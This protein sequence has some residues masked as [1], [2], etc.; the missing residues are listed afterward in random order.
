MSW[1][2]REACRQVSEFNREGIKL[3][4]VAI[5]I[6]AEQFSPAFVD[7][8]RA[9][10][11]ETGIDP[12]QLELGLT[13]AVMSSNA[14]ETVSA[15]RS[16]KES[17]IY[18]SVDDFGTGYSPLNYLSQYP[19]D[20]LKIDRSFLLEAGRSKTGA[21]LVVAIIAMA[22]SL[23]LRVLATG[24]ETESQFRFLTAHGASLIQGYLFSRPVSAEELKPMLSPWHFVDQ[25]QSLAAAEAD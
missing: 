8:V 16:L 4:K 5:N 3:G 20:E 25:V 15:L 19:L 23:D 21:N 24:V 11:D 6:S 12:G 18:L 2:L 14:P 1:V 17:G 22:H 7:S 9:T 10:I 13:E